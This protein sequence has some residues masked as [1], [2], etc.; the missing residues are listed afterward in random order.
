MDNNL[1]LRASD[2][3]KSVEYDNRNEIYFNKSN[4]QKEDHC[5][6]CLKRCKGVRAHLDYNNMEMQTN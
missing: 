5:V 3:I 6:N 2:Q 4:T 1:V